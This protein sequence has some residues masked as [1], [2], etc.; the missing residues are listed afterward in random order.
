MDTAKFGGTAKG[1]IKRLTVSDEDKRVRDW[2]KAQCEVLGC[3]VQVDSVGNM[4][5]TRAGRRKDLLPIALGSHLDTQPTGGKFDGVLGVLGALEALRTLVSAGYETN[6][7]LMVVNWTNEEG[8]RFARSMLGSAVFAGVA[9]RAE[10]DAIA[11]PD[12]VTFG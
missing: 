2:F 9:S 10:A 1:G 8:A 6:A 7:P 4:F 11:D 3:T 5:A 12:G